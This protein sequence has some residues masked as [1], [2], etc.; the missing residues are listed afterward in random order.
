MASVASRPS[1]D[2]RI[3]RVHPAQPSPPR[4]LVPARA[5]RKLWA[6]RLGASIR[7]SGPAPTADKCLGPS[8]ANLRAPPPPPPPPPPYEAQLDPPP[9]GYYWLLEPPLKT[10]PLSPRQQGKPLESACTPG[11]SVRPLEVEVPEGCSPPGFRQ[12]PI[13]LALQEGKTAT[14]RALVCGEPS[15]EVYWENSTGKLSSSS[16]FQISSGPGSGEHMLQILKLTGED[17]GLYR[18]RA[19][20]KWGQAT[21]SARLTVIEVGF[22]KNRKR[23]KEPQEDLRKELVD[24]R[25]MLRKRAPPPAPEKKVDSEQVWQLLTTA[26]R[27]DYEQICRKYGIVDFRGLLR[28]LQQMRREREDWLAQYVNAVSNLKHLKVGKDGVATFALEL[29][30]KDPESKIYLYKDGEMVPYGSDSQTKH[31]LRRL[32]KRY[33]FQIRDLRPED[34]GIY[35]VK[36]EDAGIFSTQLEAA[37]IPPRVVVPLA[38]VRCQEEGDAC[39]ECTLSSACP[40]ATW[41]FQRRPLRPSGKYQVSVSPDGLTHQLVV[42]GACPS[43]MGLYSLDAGLHASSAWLVVEGGF[44]LSNAVKGE[45]LL[46]TGSNCQLPA[47]GAWAPGAGDSGH[48]DGQEGEL[49][50][51]GPLAGSLEGAGPASGLQQPASPDELGAWSHRLTGS[52]GR[53]A[54]GPW[55]TLGVTGGPS[56]APNFWN[57]SQLCVVEMAFGSGDKG[58]PRDDLGGSGK[59][60][61]SVGSSWKLGPQG[62]KECGE[63]SGKG[64]T[65]GSLG[66]EGNAEPPFSGGLSAQAVVGG[67]TSGLCWS[68]TRSREDR[69]QL[70]AQIEAAEHKGCVGGTQA[71]RHSLA[72]GDHRS[73][74]TGTV[75]ATSCSRG[76]RAV[77]AG[78]S[79]RAPVSF[80]VTP[81]SAVT[82][83]RDGSS[84]TQRSTA[85]T[86]VVSP[87]DSGRLSLQLKDS[88]G[89]DAAPHSL[90]RAT[91]CPR[92]PGPV[93]LQEKVPG[94][95]TAEWDPS[96]DEQGD[97]PLHYTVFTRSSAF[98]PWRQ[99]ADR[100]HTTSFTL[101]GVL[102]GR[103]YHFRVVAQNE[104]GTSPPSDTPQPWCLPRP[105]RDKFTMPVPSARE[106]N[107][108]Q[109][110]Q[111]LVRLRAH[112]LPRGSACCMSCAVRGWPR[113]RVTWFKNGQSLAG[114]PA[115]HSTDILGVCS[116]ILS[117]VSPEDG[118]EYQAVAEN[119]LGQAVSTTTLIV[120]GSQVMLP[121][122]P[123]GSS[124]SHPQLRVP[125]P[126]RR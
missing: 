85:S 64:G 88:W 61:G 89:R 21:C 91:A 27:K 121:G 1:S 98:G 118:G 102:P 108:G 50:D 86:N 112:L 16:K 10:T 110:P 81:V 23:Q 8:W 119:M 3:A 9:P 60:G 111:F 79:S 87:S 73:Q 71:G 13:T 46:A 113:P 45:G 24:F 105:Q 14:F 12:K 68:L 62:E 29:D 120:M 101:L 34:A 93:R 57:G 26:D 107:L 44:P 6:P 123:G 41:Q 37:A 22:R 36:V 11:M 92:A 106:P 51:Q 69:V 39:F 7:P 2:P 99:A 122:C 32:G 84:L 54:Q 74:A 116:L 55:G 66:A 125:K 42:R 72:A 75:V 28:K 58:G 4:Q 115:V 80:E 53:G 17:T 103:Q 78:V 56:S 47:P 83:L 18:C 63:G 90:L 67:E 96:P 117:S 70:G 65:S 31:C 97:D 95:V 40:D 15:P 25:K 38:E 100:V 76:P 114:N 82:Q 20:N 43:D 124:K 104:A 19:A 59:I 77:N 48:L 109:K 30:L 126:R 33:H 5:W 94:T 52:P 35:Q 49:P